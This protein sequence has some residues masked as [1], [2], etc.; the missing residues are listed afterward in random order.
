MIYLPSSCKISRF[1]SNSF[2]VYIII[3][4]MTQIFRKNTKKRSAGLLLKLKKFG[5]SLFV[6]LEAAS[7]A[8]KS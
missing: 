7:G 1:Y 4:G 5:S 8:R 3:L 6:L 2:E